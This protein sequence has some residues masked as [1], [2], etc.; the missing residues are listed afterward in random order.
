MAWQFMGHRSNW[1]RI[2]PSGKPWRSGFLRTIWYSLRWPWVEIATTD[3]GEVLW[4]YILNF[5]WERRHCG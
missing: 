5:V 4:L 3:D 1:C 2:T